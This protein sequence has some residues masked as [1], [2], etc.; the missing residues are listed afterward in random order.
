MATEYPKLPPGTISAL[1]EA[2]RTVLDPEDPFEETLI[3]VVH[4]HRRKGEDYARDGSP[5]S[6]F[7]FCASAVGITASESALHM[8]ALKIARLG[9]LK[10]NGRTKDPRNEP[11][12][13]S[14]LDC[15]VYAVLALAIRRHPDGRVRKQHIQS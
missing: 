4:T 6:N 3:E 9:A 11:V 14:Y 13:D 8:V 7:E 1:A 5:F 2:G 10:A 12:N 15:A